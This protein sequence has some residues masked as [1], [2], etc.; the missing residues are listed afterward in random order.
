M[1]DGEKVPEELEEEDILTSLLH[2]RREARDE[3]SGYKSLEENVAFQGLMKVFQNN[4]DVLRNTLE[5][6]EPNGFDGVIKS[7]CLRGELKAI[8][9]MVAFVPMQAQARMDIIEVFDVEI[10]V[11][12]AAEKEEEKN[13]G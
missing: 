6:G 4:L 8:R 12:V 3:L 2:R 1:T 7:E 9:T 10:A 13:N 11:E 5:L